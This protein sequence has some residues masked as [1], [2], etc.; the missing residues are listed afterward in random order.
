M[1]DEYVQLQLQG[2]WGCERHSGRCS[3][4]RSLR[5]ASAGCRMGE[6]F[7]HASLVALSVTRTLVPTPPVRFL[8]CLCVWFRPVYRRPPS[9]WQKQ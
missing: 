3:T 4:R 6:S 1:Y 8:V 5:C 2:G 7:G 9:R